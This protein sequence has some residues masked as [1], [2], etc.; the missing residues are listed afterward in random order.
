[1]EQRKDALNKII[2]S[3]D[4][5]N[6]VDKIIE[7]KMSYYNWLKN[8]INPKQLLNCEDIDFSLQVEFRHLPL[9][10]TIFFPL[11]M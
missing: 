11:R 2:S 5:E 7:N 3:K 9:P 4:F 10:T 6:T 1:M 8:N